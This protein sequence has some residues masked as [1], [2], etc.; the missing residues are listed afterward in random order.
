MK[1]VGISEKVHRELMNLKINY[2]YKNTNSLLE[3]MVHE[4]KHEKLVEASKEIRK[5]M[6]EK[7][8]SFKGLVKRSRKAREEVY[9]EWFR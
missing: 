4:F 5:K 1:T 7:R 2:S 6:S 9:D 3:D 8:I